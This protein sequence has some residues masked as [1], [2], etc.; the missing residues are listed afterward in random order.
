MPSL[1]EKKKMKKN[2]ILLVAVIGLSFTLT[3][4]LKS[5]SQKLGEKMVEKT[6]ESQTGGNVDVDTNSGT[7]DFKS[8]DGTMQVSTGGEVSLPDGFP[9]DLILASDAKVVLATSADK[10]TSV[11][12]ET[13]ESAADLFA[14]YKEELDDQGWTKDFEMDAGTSK[15]VNF[16]KG[17]QRASF[18]I[19]ENT[20]SEDEYKTMVNITLSEIEE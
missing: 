14:D 7:M 18:I 8:E 3:G 13:D 16:K 4:C 19:S 1:R 10:T 5:P 2:L 15:M 12:Y 11:A 20:S 9:K 6:I 17:N